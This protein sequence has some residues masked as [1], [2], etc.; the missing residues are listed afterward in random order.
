[1]GIMIGHCPSSFCESF[2]VSDV[3]EQ[4]LVTMTSLLNV[5][6]PVPRRYCGCHEFLAYLVCG[7]SHKV[8]YFDIAW[9]VACT[10]CHAA[11]KLLPKL[12]ENFWPGGIFDCNR[13]LYIQSPRQAQACK[14]GLECVGKVSKEL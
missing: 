14:R 5:V 8:Q 13:S 12:V 9:A 7:P 3:L 10:A 1:M 4:C 11:Q 2:P 6:R